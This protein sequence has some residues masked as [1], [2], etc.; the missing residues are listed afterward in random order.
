MAIPVSSGNLVP[1]CV[2][3]DA[4]PLA[5]QYVRAT[6][7]DASTGLEVAGSPV[8][9]P[10]VTSTF[11]LAYTFSMPNISY[12]KAEF[13]LFDDAGFT[14]PSTTFRN[15]EETYYRPIT[16]EETPA[17]AP[18]YNTLNMDRS[19]TY[20]F[21]TAANYTLVGTQVTGGLSSLL[22]PNT[23]GT[24]VPVAAIQT[25]SVLTFVVTG[26]VIPANTTLTYAM[27]VDGVLK[28]WNGSAWVASDGTFSQ[29]N[30]SAD[31]ATNIPTLLDGVTNQ[32]VCFYALFETT[33]SPTTASLDALTFTYTFGGV[34]AKP[35]TCTVY[36]YY[37]D[38][39]GEGVGD[40][41]VSISLV[42][43]D[44][45]YNEASGSVIEKKKAVITQKTNN[46]GYFEFELVRSSEY[47]GS[48][49]QY[50]LEI[51]KAADG[52]KTALISDVEI[53]FT[54]P[55]ETEKN[56]TDLITAA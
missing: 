28:W 36:G 30:T 3:L 43:E 16:R 19:T 1:L 2:V 56:L 11:F 45:E 39:E 6:L 29:T 40:A 54:V 41:T 10:A 52:L 23:T 12:L 14:S 44:E 9:V 34:V 32:L 24:V 5:T 51:S 31:I 20:P 46:L 35:A 49:Q 53:T 26:E 17:V 18:C 50:L 4:T 22:S 33:A 42:R 13:E 8:T 27:T 47:E 48:A 25:R 21:T 38:I 55:D 7:R 37:R 15:T